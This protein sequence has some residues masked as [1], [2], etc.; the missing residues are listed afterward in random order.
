M[1]YL[2]ILLSWQTKLR[3][4]KVARDVSKLGRAEHRGVEATSDECLLLSVRR[5]LIAALANECVHFFNVVCLEQLLKGT[6]IL[7]FSGGCN[8]ERARGPCRLKAP[9]AGAPPRGGGHTRGG[10]LDHT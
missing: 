2:F 9:P 10:I 1:T 4:S 8:P 5:G 6:G 3:S 7:A